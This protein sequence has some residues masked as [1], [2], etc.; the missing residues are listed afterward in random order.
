MRRLNQNMTE[1][2]RQIKKFNN[3]IITGSITTI[4]ATVAFSSLIIQ[5]GESKLGIFCA[6]FISYLLGL[7]ITF[8]LGMI[9]LIFSNPASDF[10]KKSNILINLRKI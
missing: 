10:N 1:L 6:I 2:L 9:S 3:Y 4:V 8:V 5:H 7:L